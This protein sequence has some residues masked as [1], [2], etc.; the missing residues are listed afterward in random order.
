MHIIPNRSVA[1]LSYGITCANMTFLD[2]LAADPHRKC[3]QKEDKEHLDQ[4]LLRWEAE[5]IRTTEQT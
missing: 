4:Q 2:L 5:E 3:I 1:V